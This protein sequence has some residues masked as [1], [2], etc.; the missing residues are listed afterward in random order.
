MVAHANSYFLLDT[1]SNKVVRK[2]VYTLYS[3]LLV[4]SSTVGE[5]HY[6]KTKL[7][8]IIKL[9]SKEDLSVCLTYFF[10]LH[11]TKI[12]AH[13]MPRG[14]FNGLIGLCIHTPLDYFVNI[15]I[16]WPINTMSIENLAF[17]KN[18]VAVLQTVKAFRELFYW[19]LVGLWGLL[20]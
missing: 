4:I 19:L 20:S 5:T 1:D 11:F 12:H 13:K 15:N 6:G 8:F 2:D 18:G 10:M 16:S 9:L 7:R 3:L 17:D 14:H